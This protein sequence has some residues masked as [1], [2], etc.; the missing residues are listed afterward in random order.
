MS[1]QARGPSGAVLDLRT[2]KLAPGAGT[3]FD[4]ILRERALPMLRRYGIDVVAYGPSLDDGDVYYLMRA[5]SSAS[6]RDER[7]DVFYGS[8]E[9]RQSH[10]Q[11]VLALIDS[12]DTLLIGLSLRSGGGWSDSDRARS[13]WLGLA[14]AT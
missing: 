3:E 13:F 7:L 8:A 5:F 9:W 12:Y 4:R 14:S 6:A 2:Y 11:S 1:A 10:R